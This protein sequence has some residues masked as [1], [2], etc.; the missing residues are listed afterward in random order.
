VRNQAGQFAEGSQV[1]SGRQR[2]GVGKMGGEGEKQIE[3]ER[4]QIKQEEAKLNKELEKVQQTR[5]TQRS[6]REGIP[7][8][9]VVGYTNAGKSQ[10]VQALTNSP[11][12]V[13]DQLFATLDTRNRRLEFSTGN[14]CLI[15][16]TVGFISELPHILVKA[17]QSTFEDTMSADLILHVRDYSLPSPLLTIHQE[18]VMQVLQDLVKVT[19]VPAIPPIIE[20]RNKVDLLQPVRRRRLLASARIARSS[21]Q[22]IF[23]IS[24]L[25]GYNIKEL[26]EYLDTVLFEIQ[27]TNHNNYRGT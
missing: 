24:A 9:A 8:V 26:R 11:M 2:V 7:K 16:D 17:F 15:A 19:G 3:L 21:N 23:A 27:K 10:L 25:T 13:H 20:I 1:V 18:T 5:K 4:R 12:L 22:K 6:N 14:K